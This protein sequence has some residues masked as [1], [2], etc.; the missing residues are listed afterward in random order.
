MNTTPIA[1]A[2]ATLLIVGCGGSDSPSPASVDEAQRVAAATATAN[3][4]PKC[5]VATI[6][7]FYWELGDGN[8]VRASGSVGAGAPEAGTRMALYSSSKWIYAAY[9]VQKRGLV[10]AD[11]PFLN[12]SSGHT[13]FGVPTCPVASDVQSCGV[14]D[15]VDPATV[16][17][18]LYDSGHMQYHARAMMGLGGADNAALAAEMTATLG[19]FAFAYAQPHLAAGV[20]GTSQ[21]YGAFLRRIL[22]GELAI[23]DGLGW[24]RVAA[25]YGTAIDGPQVG[26]EEWDYSLGHWVETDARIGDGSYSSAGGGGFYPWI[27]GSRTLYG[28]VAR[29]RVSESDA[30]YHSAECGRLIRQAWVTGV[31]VSSTTPGG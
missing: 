3:A 27:N 12:F 20:E 9:V 5:D 28:I 14:S 26:S 8:G 17:R 2:A 25:S 18:F 7:A 1:L 6:G 30:G 10:E 13:L 22:R 19:D 16:G 4:N 29:E 15:G 21:G 11:A 23:A 24:R 31:Q